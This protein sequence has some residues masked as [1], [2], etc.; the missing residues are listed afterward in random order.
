YLC[1]A[2][3][4]LL[5]ACA[6]PRIGLAGAAW[7]G[8][9]LIFASTL[10]RT[11]WEVFRIGYVAGLGLYLGQLYLLLFI[12]FWLYGVPVGR[13]AGW[14]AL[15]AYLALYPAAWVWLVSSRRSHGGAPP[16][17]VES[18]SVTLSG[19][20]PGTWLGRLRWT[21]IGAAVWVG[22]EMILTR[23]FSG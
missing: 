14:I 9:G 6:F 23:L 18:A 19:S 17:P 8:P 22:L 13:A 2:L 1:A 5:L 10:G 7:I 15:S 16:S 20:L 11:G 21:L 4:G 3:S 12:S